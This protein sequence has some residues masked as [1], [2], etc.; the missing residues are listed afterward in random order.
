MAKF[1]GQR[2]VPEFE[3]KLIDL[4]RVTRVMAGGKRLRFRACVIVGNRKGKVGFAVDKGAD[5]AI[6]VD[7][8][9]RKAQKNL[10]TVPLVNN[11]IPHEIKVKFKAAQIILKPAPQGTGVISGGAVRSVMELAGVQN[12]VTKI[13]GTSNKITNVMATFLALKKF[14]KVNQQKSKTL[15]DKVK[16]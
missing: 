16:N 4:A 11:T 1:P 5:V 3:Q 14:K 15:L 8:A 2:A 7:K 6:A 12:V 9:A 10:L 13:L